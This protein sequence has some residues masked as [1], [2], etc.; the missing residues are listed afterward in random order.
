[1]RSG[2]RQTG[3]PQTPASASFAG[4]MEAHGKAGNGMLQ[5]LLFV[6]TR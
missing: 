3:A 4:H 5:F 6:K 2:R 1:M